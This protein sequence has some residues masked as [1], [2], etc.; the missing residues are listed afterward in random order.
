MLVS[1]SVQSKV[2]SKLC[3]RVVLLIKK[4]KKKAK[5]NTLPFAYILV[6]FTNVNTKQLLFSYF[7]IDS[8]FR[9]VQVVYKF[10]FK[11]KRLKSLAKK[12]EVKRLSRRPKKAIIAVS[13]LVNLKEALYI[14]IIVIKGAF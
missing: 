8:I 11:C 5:L 3:A 12:A 1:S 10:Y 14:L 2:Q 4:P 7:I 6:L 13:K 9:E